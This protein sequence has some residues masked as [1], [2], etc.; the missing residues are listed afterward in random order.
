MRIGFLGLGLMGTPMTVN[1]ARRFRHVSAWNRTA[2][3]TEALAAA[4]APGVRRCGTPREVLERSDTVF[5]MLL[6]GG[7][8]RS[9]V[10][11]AGFRAGLRGKTIVNAA[12]VSVECSLRL[13]EEVRRA[14]GR[15]VEMPVSGGKVPAERG[16]LVGML[17]AEEE[18]V[19]EEVKGSGCLEP[20]VKTAV[21]CGPIGSALKTKYAVNAFLVTLTAGL[22]ESL[23]LARAQGID[24][25][26]VGEVLDAGPLASAFTRIKVGKVVRGDWS[27][28]GAISVC[29]D[30]SR[31]ICEAARREGLRSPLL[32]AAAGLFRE[33]DERGLGGE[34]M[35]A[36]YKMLREQQQ[37][38]REEMQPLAGQPLVSV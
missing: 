17:A 31:H 11:D 26:A 25:A 12:S 8:A 4:G 10:G 24:L 29:C 14:G 32:E 23:N 3:R 37:E 28:H 5:M 38:R 1:L 35:M 34:D 13:A 22:A 9:V 30:S 33:A 36:L 16:E 2:A 18:S 20:L 15:F 6:D 21:Y 7:A 27:A 19:A